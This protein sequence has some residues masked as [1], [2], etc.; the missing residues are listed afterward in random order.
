MPEPEDFNCFICELDDEGGWESMMDSLRRLTLSGMVS[1]NVHIVN[2]LL[3]LAQLMEYPYDLLREN[4][5]L[6]D[7]A[8]ARLRSRY[9]IARWTVTGG[10]YGS[11]AQVRVARRALSLDLGRFGR[12]RFL[13]DRTMRLFEA[14][15][16]LWSKVAD[17]PLLPQLFRLISRSSLEKAGAIPHVY[18]IL[19]GIPGEHI[20]KFAYFKKRGP[21]PAANLDP[22]RASTGH[23]RERSHSFRPH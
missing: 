12:V 15:V 8:R 1:A 10:L 14:F 21:C 18:P 16:R 20:L 13:N 11:S 23:R 19:K 4:T 7:E 6:S 5:Y 2:D 3:F 9:G 22:A 17:L